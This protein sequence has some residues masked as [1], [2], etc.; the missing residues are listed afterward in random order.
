MA[1]YRSAPNTGKGNCNRCAV[2]NGRYQVKAC[3]IIGPLHQVEG[4]CIDVEVQSNKWKA[5][6]VCCIDTGATTYL[7]DQ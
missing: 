5:G 4:H 1:K 2:C 6:C 3:N 7:S